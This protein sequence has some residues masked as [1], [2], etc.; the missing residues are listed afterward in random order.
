[1]YFFENSNTD[2]TIFGLYAQKL[3]STGARRWGAGALALVP[4]NAQPRMLLRGAT[5]GNDAVVIFLENTPGSFVYSFVKAIRVNPAGEQ[6]WE[7]SPQTLSNVT[8]SKGYLDACANSLGQTIAVW[9]D[10]RIDTDGDVYLQNINA[11]GSLG[12]LGPLPGAIEGLVMLPDGTTP[13]ESVIVSTF[14][15]G[16]VLVGTDTTGAD[17]IYGLI[18]DPGTYHELLVK[19]G[20]QDTTI[21]NIVVVAGVTTHVGVTLRE[22]SGC[23]YIP[24]DFNFNGAPNGIDVVYG[25]NYFKGGSA[26]PVDCGY[27]VGPCP[28]PSPFYAA[29]DVNGNCAVNGIDITF[30]VNFLK[31]IQPALLYCPSCPPAM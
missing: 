25:V 10:N 11:D 18:L 29:M 27:P 26:P 12:P 23:V 30:F 19:P 17:G 9:K 15:S 6:V 7:P 2:Q 22:R 24:G 3:D 28:Q 4:M 5:V 31:G 16:D 1:M 21:D 14:D 20:Y 8:N 13:A